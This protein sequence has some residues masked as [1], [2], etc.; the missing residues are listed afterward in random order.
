MSSLISLPI[1]MSLFCQ[2]TIVQHISSFM[3]SLP[4]VYLSGLILFLSLS[5]QKDASKPFQKHEL[6]PDAVMNRLK[7]FFFLYFSCLVVLRF[8]LIFRGLNH[9]LIFL[10]LPS[11]FFIFSALLMWLVFAL[12]KAFNL[13]SASGTQNADL[14]ARFCQRFRLSP[15][16]QD[17]LIQLCSGKSNGQIADHLFITQNT[18]KFHI[19]H[20]YQKTGVKNRVQLM[21]LIANH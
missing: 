5:R 18:V 9:D 7:W 1:V 10:L 11:H 4:F 21:N 16:E 19:S 8:L 3:M 14:I 20:I 17:I 15:K 2:T 6:I 13:H 12:T